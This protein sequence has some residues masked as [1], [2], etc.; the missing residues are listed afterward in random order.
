MLPFLSRLPSTAHSFCALTVDRLPSPPIPRVLPLPRPTPKPPPSFYPPYGRRYLC[1]SAPVTV[2]MDAELASSGGAAPKPTPAQIRQLMSELSVPSAER[3]PHYPPDSV[4]PLK[5]CGRLQPSDLLMVHHERDLSGVPGCGDVDHYG[6]FVD[7]DC[8]D[9][10]MSGGPA[11]VH[12]C[13][14]TLS[15]HVF[16]GCVA[17]PVLSSLVLFSFVSLPRCVVRCA[18]RLSD[19][20]TVTDVFAAAGSGSLG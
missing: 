6:I 2:A 19:G 8:R 4:V 10:G 18:T 20:F 9:H 12:F 13:K 16:A 14:L 3:G 5:F 15:T 11:V 7:D 1:A 17:T